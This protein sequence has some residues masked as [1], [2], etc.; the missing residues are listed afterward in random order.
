MA[1]KL[2]L[3]RSLDLDI[4]D[5]SGRTVTVELWQN[6][7]YSKDVVTGATT[8][9][10]EVHT[11][12]TTA[13]NH[14]P[15]GTGYTFR[16]VNEAA[17]SDY[18]ALATAFDMVDDNEAA[19]PSMAWPGDD[20]WDFSFSG[21]CFVESS[22]GVGSTPSDLYGQDAVNG[23]IGRLKSKVPS[24]NSNIPVYELKQ[25]TSANKPRL[26]IDANGFFMCQIGSDVG[27]IITLTPAAAITNPGYI[28]FMAVLETIDSNGASDS[29]PFFGVVSG[30]CVAIDEQNILITDSDSTSTIAVDT[31]LGSPCVLEIGISNSAAIGESWVRLNNGAKQSFSGVY[32]SQIAA[33][34]QIMYNRGG[35]FNL[36]SF[37]MR[38]GEVTGTDYTNWYNYHADHAGLPNI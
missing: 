15:A 10:I 7:L 21:K 19:V 14:I 34:S 31:S 38:L 6:G 28:H 30:Q 8:S 25:T 24:N 22:S 16:V 27:G 18:T 37:A 36:Y 29:F 23:V 11:S 20:G 1:R 9:P 26:Y 17:A 4:G 12:E 13:T 3:D 2:F 5:L 32:W 33:S 35:Y